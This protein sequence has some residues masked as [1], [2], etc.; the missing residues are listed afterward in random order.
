MITTHVLGMPA[1]NEPTAHDYQPTHPKNRKPQYLIDAEDAEEKAHR[2]MIAA[3]DRHE[4]GD[5]NNPEPTM[6][7]L[8]QK[9]RIWNRACFRLAQARERHTEEQRR[10]YE[11]QEED[12][13][14][15]REMTNEL[16]HGG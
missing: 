11:Y 9:M 15:W 5:I 14:E 16:R 1:S 2:E 7:E 12:A 3:A 4:L 13:R 8:Q 6:R 10:Y